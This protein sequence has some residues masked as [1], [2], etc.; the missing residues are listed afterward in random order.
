MN[1]GAAKIVKDYLKVDNEILKTSTVLNWT[2]L[3]DTF[4][5]LF[6]KNIA[7]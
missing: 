5:R 6:E 3:I 4:K 7:S 1:K 2:K